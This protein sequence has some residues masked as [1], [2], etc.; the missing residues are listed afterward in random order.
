[1]AMSALRRSSRCRKG[2]AA[3]RDRG[4]DVLRGRVRAAVVTIFQASSE[5]SI[6]FT[7]PESEAERAVR[8]IQQAFSGEIASGLI[9]NVTAKPGMAVIA[10]VG[11]GMA[12][13]PGIAARVFSALATAHINV[14]AIAQGSSERNISFAVNGSD[15]ADAARCC[16][17]PSSCPR[18]AVD[19]PPRRSGPIWY[20]LASAGSA[21][22]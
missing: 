20:C 21:G 22:R 6:G 12:G 5:S 10:V 19:A 16:T 13:T 18:S 8:S 17:R 9:D 7:L 2:M 4:P 11:D 3:A 1:M 15:A 14:V